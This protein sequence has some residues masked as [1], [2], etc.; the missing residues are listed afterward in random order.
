M[1]ITIS[2][3]NWFHFLLWIEFNDIF[4]FYFVTTNMFWIRYKFKTINNAKK[5][6]NYV[7]FPKVFISVLST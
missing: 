7:L 2:F 3:S 4:K 1:C 5:Y 6:Q